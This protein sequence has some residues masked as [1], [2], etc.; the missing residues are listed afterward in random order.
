MTD[1]DT[2]DTDI[3][4][5]SNMKEIVNY[6]NHNYPEILVI[7]NKYAPKL[8]FADRCAIL[9]LV[10]M[11]LDRRVVAA[12]YGINR[13]T[14]TH[15]CSSS[16]PHYRTIRNEFFELGD[17]RFLAKYIDHNV[18]ARY[19]RHI[20][21]QEPTY[22]DNELKEAKKAGKAPNQG[23][24]KRANK[25]MGQHRV[26]GMWDHPEQ[27]LTLSVEWVDNPGVDDAAK[28]LYDDDAPRP[29]GWYVKVNDEP[30]YYGA[31]ENSR[32]SKS[33]LDGFMKDHLM[34]FNDAQI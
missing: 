13:S 14:L 10:K 12:A 25:L 30:D 29:A 27:E 22:S 34:E 7:N 20:N 17:D 18:I 16:S 1:P 33:A 2:P 4:K 21:A 15:I 3:P 24:N 9:G 8:T 5:F 6:I 19:K 31:A 23:A 28:A 11:G 26:V 32:T